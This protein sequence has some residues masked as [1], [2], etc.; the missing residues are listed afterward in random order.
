MKK[1]IP[2]WLE[3]AV[4]YQIYPQS[5][6]DSNGDGIGD[7]KGIKA[8]LDYIKWL[9]CNVIWLNPIHPSPFGDA[10]YDVT[11][12]YNVAPRYGTKEEMKE[13]ICSAH[14]RDIKVVLDIVAGHTSS[15]HPWFLES[16]KQNKNTYSNW[17]IWADETADTGSEKFVSDAVSGKKYLAN[18]YDFQPSLNYGYAR[19]D[20][21]K[22]WQLPVTHPD[23]QAMRAELLAILEFWAQMGM[24]G[25]RVDMAAS[26]VKEDRDGDETRKLWGKIR[27]VLDQKYPE[28]A[29]ISEWSCPAAAIA[30]GFHVDFLI[31]FN[32]MA[33][34]T[35][36]RHEQGRNIFDAPAEN[37]KSFFDRAGQ[38]NILAFLETYLEHYEKTKKKGFISIPSG[39]HDLPRI[40]FDRTEEELKVIFA[41]LLTMPGVPVI[42]YG[43]EIGM[44]H[45]SDVESVEGAQLNDSPVSN[46]AGARTPM[47]WT[48]GKNRG[49]SEAEEKDLYLPVDSSPCAPCVE[50]QKDQESSLLHLIRKLIALRQSRDAL[51]AGGEFEVIYARENQYPFAYL[52]SSEKENIVVVVN[53]SARQETFE[54]KLDFSK[55]RLLAGVP[56]HADSSGALYAQPISFSIYE[57]K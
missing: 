21:E 2:S 45:L 31:H 42:Y 4:I 14:D 51:R 30:A 12:F 5:F 37:A 49:F 56:L 1:K 44:R 25:F 43:D 10:G 18:F 11:D 34:T 29:L 33:Y 20:P 24:D 26:L 39:N 19:P 28:A 55:A 23:V 52:R 38:G 40:C 35:L 48:K 7:I 27:S 46:R 22:P 50:E 36:F 53:P 16:R 15:L 3:D 6:F 54:T 9:G 41:F 17:Y 47:Q 57:L 13:L 8:K 32:S